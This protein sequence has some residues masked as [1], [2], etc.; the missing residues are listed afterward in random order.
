MSRP[1]GPRSGSSSG[2]LAGIVATALPAAAA[3]VVFGAVFGAAARPLVG[4]PLT[5][6]ASALIFSGAL[7]FAVLGLVGAG[8][9]APALLATGAALN[10]RHVVLGAV[11]RNA[12][13][14]PAPRRAGLAWFLV[15]ETFGFALAAG[16]DAGR[17]LLV[18][19]V[20]CYSAWQLGTAIGV[21]GAGLP[22]LDGIATAVFPVLF[23]GLA[24]LA[25]TDLDLAGRAVAGAVLTA[26]LVYS[27]P[28]LRGVA[29]VVA[30]IAVALPDRRT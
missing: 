23:I 11:L 2:G 25:A 18:T 16:K 12:L 13:Q 26:A 22:G 3:I 4:A 24:A 14:E 30:G 15:D 7:Q 19:G 28:G 5:L 21:L 29:P 20:M 8:A 9:A 17:T 10:V 27:A 1:G 6:L